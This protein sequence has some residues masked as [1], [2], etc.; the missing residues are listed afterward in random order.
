MPPPSVAVVPP[1]GWSAA[2]LAPPVLAGGADARVVHW[3][4]FAAP[5]GRARLLAG[6]VAT[7]IPG[8]VEDMRPAVE[9]R[10]RGL[11]DGSADR[12][13]GGDA[14]AL[15]RTFLG[16]TRT[17]VVTCFATCAAPK[18]T[19]PPVRACDGAVE[20]ARLEG[21]AAPPPA[22]LALGTVTWGVHHPRAA[23]AGGALATFLVA[24]VAVA[25]RR[26]PRSRI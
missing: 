21:G 6:C 22:G 25:A 12:L 13:V 15:T 24:V 26:R 3:S 17:E 2:E 1:A 18:S 7:P 20:A 8:W 10:A 19:S 11:A 5:D 16:F 4:A 14:A 9:A 23:V